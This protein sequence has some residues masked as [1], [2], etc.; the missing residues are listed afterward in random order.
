MNL[1]KVTSHSSKKHQE[2]YDTRNSNIAMHCL[3]APAQSS[4]TEEGGRREHANWHLDRF[5]RIEHRHRDDDI[6]NAPQR[7]CALLADRE[8]TANHTS[9][10]KNSIAQAKTQKFHK[11]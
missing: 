5:S 3:K 2:S 8:H 10:R 11:L 9:P 7:Y 1:Q 4:Q 6:S